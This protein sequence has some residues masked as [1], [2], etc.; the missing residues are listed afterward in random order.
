M[1]FQPGQ[2]G[3]PG[4]RPKSKPFKDAL[5]MEALAA[6]RGEKCYAKKGSLR[7]NARQL[8]I[9]GEVAAI[10]EIADRLDGKVTQGI[11]GPDGG[12]IQTVDLTNVSADDLDRLEALFGPLAGGP[13]DDDEGDP[14]G[15]GEES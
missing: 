9:K 10:R 13:G 5:M 11:S 14:S 12:P 7:W 1:K 2:S 6:E 4:G 3:N 15:E 8:L